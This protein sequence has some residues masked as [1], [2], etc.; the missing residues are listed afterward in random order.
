MAPRAALLKPNAVARGNGVETGTGTLAAALQ[1]LTDDDADILALLRA[2]E[3][4]PA[5]D[6]LAARYGARVYRL[7]HA[8]VRDSA[9]AEDV[10]QDSLIRVWRALPGFDGRARLS[11]WIYAIARNRS[12]TALSRRR[13]TEVLDDEHLEGI[14]GDAGQDV[15]ADESQAQLRRFV[16]GLP[17]KLRIP[18]T[19]YYYEDRSVAEVATRLGIPEATVK[20]HLARGRA[21]LLDRLREAGLA[22]ASLWMTSTR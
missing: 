7:C 14:A 20:T 16:D 19:L 4:A 3:A 9:L 15:V 2:G 5:F 12:L 17:D 11:S 10:A 18:L 22:E 21:R 13:P 1:E 6:L 8:F